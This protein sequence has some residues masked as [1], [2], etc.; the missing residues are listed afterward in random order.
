MLIWRGWRIQTMDSSDNITTHIAMK[1]ET[2]SHSRHVTPLPLIQSSLECLIGSLA[3]QSSVMKYFSRRLLKYFPIMVTERRKLSLFKT[4][5][6][7]QIFS[8]QFYLSPG[9]ILNLILTLNYRHF[10]IEW[11]MESHPTDARIDGIKGI[12]GFS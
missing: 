6:F 8:P 1:P 11:D 7:G 9:L 5:N 12:N 3:Q 4:S 10:E 2:L